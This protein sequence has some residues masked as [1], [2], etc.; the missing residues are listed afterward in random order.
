MEAVSIF[1]QHSC[2]DEISKKNWLVTVLSSFMVSELK[3]SL[4]STF[5]AQLDPKSGQWKSSSGENKGKKVSFICT[6]KHVIL[7][8][9]IKNLGIRSTFQSLGLP[10]LFSSSS[11][12]PNNVKN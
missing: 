12:L 7:P 3:P 6:L 10:Y 2:S 11:V 8:P 9:A 5:P 1:S 4:V